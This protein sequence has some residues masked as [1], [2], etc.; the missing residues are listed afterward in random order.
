MNHDILSQHMFINFFT[1]YCKMYKME[2][3]KIASMGYCLL[4]FFRWHFNFPLFA[5]DLLS[6]K[7]IGLWNSVK[8]SKTTPTHHCTHGRLCTRLVIYP[9]GWHAH[10]PGVAIIHMICSQ[11]YMYRISSKCKNTVTEKYWKTRSSLYLM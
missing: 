3:Q 11:L 8:K 7:I 5:D 2:Q 9:Y 1:L 6:A 4:V 10:S